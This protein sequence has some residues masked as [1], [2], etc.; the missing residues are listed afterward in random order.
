MAKTLHWRSE[1][2]FWEK[3]FQNLRM[4]I[5]N[6]KVESKPSM[7]SKFFNHSN[8]L[9]N[10][11]SLFKEY[12][13]NTFILNSL[14]VQTQCTPFRQDCTRIQQLVTVP[15][16]SEPLISTSAM[17]TMSS[18]VTQATVVRHLLCHD[19]VFH[20]LST[21]QECLYCQLKVLVVPFKIKMTNKVYT[22]KDNSI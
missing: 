9:L 12:C 22:L 11:G 15:S 4:E 6:I 13:F 17:V 1:S 10:K 3:E 2:S 7:C 18:Q 21:I 8:Y 14:F 20:D 19:R 16:Y 5:Q